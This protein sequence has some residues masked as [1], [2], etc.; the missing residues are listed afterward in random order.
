MRHRKKLPGL[1]L[2]ALGLM[3]ILSMILPTAFWWFVFGA[4]LIAAGICMLK[5]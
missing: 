1:I 3:I 4:V 2:T 5:R